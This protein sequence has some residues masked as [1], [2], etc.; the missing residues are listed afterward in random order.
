MRE[1]TEKDLNPALLGRNREQCLGILKAANLADSLVVEGLP[2][3]YG[4][5]SAGD[6]ILAKFNLLRK[7]AR[8]R[9][10]SNTKPTYAQ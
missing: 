9:L 6:C 5:R 10:I 8:I 7:G 3:S 4:K 2:T 1:R